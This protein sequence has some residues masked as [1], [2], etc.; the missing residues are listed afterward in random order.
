MTR[1]VEEANEKIKG[2]TISW[3]MNN[4]WNSEC[5]QSEMTVMANKCM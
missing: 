1:A 3:E 4:I 2:V 5:I